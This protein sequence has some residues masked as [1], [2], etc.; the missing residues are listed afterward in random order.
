MDFNAVEIY[1]LPFWDDDPTHD[2]SVHY[3]LEDNDITATGIAEAAEKDQSLISFASA[4]YMDRMLT[5]YKNANAV[6]VY[7][8]YTPKYLVEAVGERLKLDRDDMLKIRYENTRIDCS[9]LEKRFGANR[10]S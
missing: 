2:L 9:N 5:V 4:Q 8:M 3:M 7:S 10:R 6:I 1:T